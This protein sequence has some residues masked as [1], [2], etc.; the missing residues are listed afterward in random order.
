MSS[1]LRKAII[2]SGSSGAGKTTIAKHL[3]KHNA[4]SVGF[5]VSAC[6]RTRRPYEIHGRDYY[7][8]SVSEFKR[9]IA[10]GAF[11]EW[12]EVY[13]GSYYGTLKSELERIWEHNKA[14]IFDM[15]VQGAL[16]LK[17]FFKENALAVYVGVPST[18][19]LVTRLKNRGT[20]QRKNLMLRMD[21]VLK[22]TSLA[23][24]FDTI[25]INKEL[26]PSLT[27]A[28]MLLDRFLN[29]HPSS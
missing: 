17:S 2:F 28:Q 6:T 26:E 15:D 1:E 25:L 24:K 19:I 7:F 8:L 27:K 12:E 3:L 9:Q 29:I 13:Q 23:P 16:R 4:S 18:D 11:L 5:S 21:R 14:V 20:E 10:H 22:E